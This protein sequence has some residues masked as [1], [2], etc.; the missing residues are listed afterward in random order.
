MTPAASKANTTE[1]NIKN[2][3]DIYENIN[4]MST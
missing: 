1:K 4:L 3:L 2:N